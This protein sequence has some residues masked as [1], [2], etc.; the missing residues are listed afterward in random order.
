MKHLLTVDYDKTKSLKMVINNLL[1]DVFNDILTIEETALKNGPFSDVTITEVHTVEAV[2]MYIKKTMGEVAKALHI[3]VGT[4]TVSIGNLVKKGYVERFRNDIDRRVVKVGL[5]K[6]GRLLYRIHQHFHDQMVSDAI[7]GFTED[8][9][10]IFAEALTKL[11][12]SL[13]NSYNESNSREAQFV[14][15]KPQIA[16]DRRKA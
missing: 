13:R 11:H 12:D 2:G 7:A 8:E 4:L 15:N 16:A 1:V 14:H 6:K 9:S 10:R 3:T 5:T